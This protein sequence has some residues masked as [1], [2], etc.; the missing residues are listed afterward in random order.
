M[1]TLRIYL[2]KQTTKLHF[3]LRLSCSV[4]IQDG[5]IDSLC[6]VL[7]PFVPLYTPA[8]GTIVVDT[9]PRRSNSRWEF[10]YFPMFNIKFLYDIHISLSSI[11]DWDIGHK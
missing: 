4:S 3:R 8:K 2:D 1:Y 5:L 9:Y 11:L 10:F 7:R 6:Q